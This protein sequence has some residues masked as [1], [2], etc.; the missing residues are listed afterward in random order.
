M[1][2]YQRKKTRS[3]EH[4]QRQTGAELLLYFGKT[5]NPYICTLRATAHQE[6]TQEIKARVNHQDQ[7]GTNKESN[8]T[9]EQ[10]TS[11]PQM[12]EKTSSAKKLREGIFS[13]LFFHIK[14][15]KVLIKCD[16]KKRALK[17]K[18][19]NKTIHN[20]EA[21]RPRTRWKT[22]CTWKPTRKHGY[23]KVKMD[24]KMH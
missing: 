2:F 9:K 5:Q 8:Y 15:E 21:L 14:N 11:Q 6:K 10:I 18:K 22:W 19:Q 12:G 13:L 20:M 24:D 23:T 17:T 16:T 4:W 7:N 3:K 1:V